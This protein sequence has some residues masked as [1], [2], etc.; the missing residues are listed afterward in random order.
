MLKVLECSRVIHVDTCLSI[1]LDS[2]VNFILSGMTRFRFDIET[3][4][5]SAVLS[6]QLLICGELEKR[7]R[8]LML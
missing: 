1:H 4:P 2:F 7:N 8:I 5:L 6:A 3:Q